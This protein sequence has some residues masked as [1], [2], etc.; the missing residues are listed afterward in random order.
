MCDVDKKEKKKDE[1]SK[2][3]IFKVLAFGI[4]YNFKVFPI[5]FF[6]IN[7]ISIIHGIS[8]GVTTFA[9]QSFYDSVSNVITNNAPLRQAYLMIIALGLTFI[10]K[11]VLNG[12][13]NFMHGV[14]FTKS[15]GEM[16]KI[17]HDKMSRIDPVCLENTKLHDDIEKASQGA[18]AVHRLVNM[19]ITIFTFYLPYLIFMGYYL[20]HLKPQFICA[21]VLVFIPV[22]L[23]QFIRT[24][25]IARFE[26]KAAPIRREYNYYDRAI[27]DR[28]YY[29]ETRIFGAYSFFLGRFL[30][31]MKKLSKTELN[32]NR[33]TNQLE[34]CISLLSTGGYMGI[35]YMLVT[36]LLAGEITVGAFAAVFNS[37]G[38]LFIMMR[39]MI[40]YH[41]GNMA[42]NMGKAYNFIRFMEMPERGGINSEPIYDRGIIAENISFIYPFCENKSVNDISLEIKAGETV[43]IVGKNGA[44]KTTLVRLL[45]GLYTPTEGKVIINGMDTA[46]V[47]SKS[48]FNGLSGV[49]QLFQ[50]YQMTLQENIQ[51]SDNGNARVIDAAIEQAGVDINSSNFPNG[52]ATI[53]SREFDGV[54]LSGGEW[55]RVAIARGL[56]R[57][58]NVILLDEPT[59]AIDP[60]EESRIYR[61]FIEI[62]KDK[63]SI[64]VTHRLG[65][66]KI[67]DRV[68]VMD[69][70]KIIDIGSHYELMQKDGLYAK[71]FHSQADWYKEV[72]ED[73]LSE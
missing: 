34:L 4:K 47:N 66:T 20:H 44:G 73:T 72:M 24:S 30:N 32:A 18:Q 16:S 3:S 68:I 57:M 14:M 28:E 40:N 13:H 53:L 61:K 10:V 42:S 23:S 48:V 69:R 67:A 58:H 7:I 64:I 5:Y 63:T 49:F 45:M 1:H 21:I 33:K 6:A 8:Q 55:Q 60:I 17:I 41:I 12:V 15:S 54:D 65:A 11:D 9:T 59:A 70:G 2:V 50:R 27:T 25:I 22:L 31:T 36:A 62:S 51:I 19:G 39:E 37:I 52:G 46:K 71:M 29:K 38:L 43:A 26:D 56:Y 35:L